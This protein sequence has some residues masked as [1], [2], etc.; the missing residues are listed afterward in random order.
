MP[1]KTSDLTVNRFSRFLDA[2]EWAGNKLPNP[3]TLFAVLAVSVVLGSAVLAGLE[4][5][6]LHPTNG[7]EIRAVNLLSGE[8][9]RRILT[10]LVSNFA[11]FAPLGTVL[12]ALLGVGVAEG[13]GLL[14]ALIRGLVLSAPRRLIT[15]IVVL[16]GIL[17][18]AAS[19]AGYVILIPLAAVIFHAV[20]RHPLAGLAAA[21]AGVS[22]GYSANLV[23]GTIDPLLAGITQEA[24][25]I[26]DPAYTVNPAANYYFLAA[27]TFFLVVIGT[28]VSEK[29]VEPRLGN[30]TGGSGEASLTPLSPVE[31]RGLWAAGFTV[32]VLTALVLWG[33]LPDRGVLRDP[34][35]NDIL[36]SPFLTGIVA[37]IFLGFL[38]PGI[39]YG[40][41]TRSIR[42]DNDVITAMN[43]AMATLGSY[44]VLV[45]FAA[46]F[47]AFFG[48]TNIGIITAIQGAEF[49]QTIGLTG[50]PLI[51]AFI[52]LSAVLNLLMG[53]AS[54]KWAVMA[55]VFVPMFMLLGYTP[56]LTQVAYRVGDSSTNV[57][58]PMMSYF[59]LI[60][61]YVQRY[62]SDAGLG[63]LIALMLPYS[64]VF[65]VAW[66]AL[67]FVWMSVGLP[68]GPG[69][70]LRL[71]P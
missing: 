4:F 50:I 51:V 61:A 31:K 46:Q 38:A 57:I 32:M 43:K 34:A 13:S 3:A 21:F 54:A 7:T 67:L 71:M 25:R 20:G 68:V 53:S 69:A 52:L 41:I 11:G 56:E 5:V 40:L 16:A 23:L 17:S 42:S 65:L 59:A 60:A 45:F 8:G 26:I 44:I 1:Q 22:G 35:Y 2:V 27:S 37:F 55:P 39:A 36:H 15:P 47:V 10:S 64:V 12:V 6:A 14:S 30:Y 49:L 19:E 29:I 58:T 62:R 63:T 18:N 24:A 70:E 9:I 66:S 28:L 33:L 48:W